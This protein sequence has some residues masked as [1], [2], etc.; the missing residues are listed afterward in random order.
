M[1]HRL[2]IVEVHCLVLMTLEKFVITHLLITLKNRYL[3]HI[4]RS[5]CLLKGSVLLL[6]STRY[7]GGVDEF[8]GIIPNGVFFAII[9]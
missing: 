9:Y 8:R 3:V 6:R 2:I 1:I 4:S 7:C 5:P